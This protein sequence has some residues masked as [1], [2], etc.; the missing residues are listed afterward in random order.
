MRIG[1]LCSR[2]RV[3]EK[4]IFAEFERRVDALRVLIVGGLRSKID[5]YLRSRDTQ[6]KLAEVT[7]RYLHGTA[8]NCTLS[9]EGLNYLDLI[10]PKEMPQTQ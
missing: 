6:R 9:A 7:R 3:E 1:V 4:L 8:P 2:V 10:C 5:L